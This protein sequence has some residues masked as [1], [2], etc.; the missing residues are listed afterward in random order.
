MDGFEWVVEDLNITGNCFEKTLKT[1]GN[2]KLIFKVRSLQMVTSVDSY[3]KTDQYGVLIA[4]M[5]YWTIS[6]CCWT[7]GV[8]YSVVLPAKVSK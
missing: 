3:V 7:S 5:D 8:F 2:K 6:K 4:R 1:D